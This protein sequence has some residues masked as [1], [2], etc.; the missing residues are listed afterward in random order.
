MQCYAVKQ[1]AVT[2]FLK[3]NT[4]TLYGSLGSDVK[5]ILNVTLDLQQHKTVNSYVK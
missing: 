1:T 3:I 5:M 2:L 4:H